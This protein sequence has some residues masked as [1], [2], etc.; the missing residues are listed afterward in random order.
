MKIHGVWISFSSLNVRAKHAT[1]ICL[2]RFQSSTSFTGH[3]F[4]GFFFQVVMIRHVLYRPGSG[5]DMSLPCCL[6]S[7]SSQCRLA[8][9]FP[10]CLRPLSKSTS[11]RVDLPEGCHPSHVLC[12]ITWVTRAVFLLIYEFP[13][14]LREGS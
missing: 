5:A 2:N 1:L 11:P 6:C 7:S 12:S 4:L 10:R 3:V 9:R 13:A 14:L 8:P